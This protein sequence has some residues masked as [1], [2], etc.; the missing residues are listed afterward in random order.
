MAKVYGI[1]NRSA[2]DVAVA[3][4]LPEGNVFW[5]ET[6]AAGA[7]RTLDVDRARSRVIEMVVGTPS[8]TSGQGQGIIQEGSAVSFYNSAFLS[9]G[10]L[11]FDVFDDKAKLKSVNQN[12]GF[13]DRLDASFVVRA[14]LSDPSCVSLQSA[15]YPGVYLQAA[16][17]TAGG[18]VRTSSPVANRAT[19]CVTE[20]NSTQV[21]LRLADG[22]GRWLENTGL[23]SVGLKSNS[24]NSGLWRLDRG[25]ADPQS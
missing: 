8:A 14:G 11:G 16:A 12:S 5:Q 25:L 13:E 4:R 2:S 3:F 15:S 9:Q 19:W 18:V 20:V 24:S 1:Y 22:T 17:A 6:I 23:G 10:T 7:V 21:R